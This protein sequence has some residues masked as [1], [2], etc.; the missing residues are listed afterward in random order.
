MCEY[1]NAD[2]LIGENEIQ[3]S[4]YSADPDE[5][6][7]QLLVLLAD[8][9]QLDDLDQLRSFDRNLFSAFW[10]GLRKAIFGDIQLNLAS[11]GDD[12]SSLVKE[13]FETIS[14]ARKEILLV[15]AD[16]LSKMK[17]NAALHRPESKANSVPFDLAKSQQEHPF[18][19]VPYTKLIHVTRKLVFDVQQF[20]AELSI[21]EYELRRLIGAQRNVASTVLSKLTLLDAETLAYCMVVV[22]VTKSEPDFAGCGVWKKLTEAYLSQAKGLIAIAAHAMATGMIGDAQGD[23]EAD[24]WKEKAVALCYNLIQEIPQS[25][26]KYMNATGDDRSRLSVLLA[27][28]M[29]LKNV[30]NHPRFGKSLA[31]FIAVSFV[32]LEPILDEIKSGELITWAEQEK[33]KV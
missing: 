26:R 18:K 21:D 28:T 24:N 4:G 3:H 29:V 20:V 5:A 30:L 2:K 27:G 10:L 13:R 31:K 7:S 23:V 16:T 9:V 14:A 25:A 15:V 11:E 12:L 6:R 19:Y 1:R 32:T 8:D 22:G 17:P 33:L